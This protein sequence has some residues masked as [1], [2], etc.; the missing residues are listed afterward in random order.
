MTRYG[1]RAI[2]QA[3]SW[4]SYVEVT[5]EVIFELTFFRDKWDELNGCPIRLD[6]SRLAVNGTKTQVASDA[7]AV[8]LYIYEV[9]CGEFAF[10]RALTPEEAQESS[11]SRE[12]MCFEEFYFHFGEQL[13]GKSVVHYSDANNVAILLQIGS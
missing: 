1:F 11:S 13:R 8:G 3:F 5:Q 6:R 7:S 4:H 2:S 10:K 12:L 9:T